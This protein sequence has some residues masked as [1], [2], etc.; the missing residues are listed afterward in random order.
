MRAA[1]TTAQ[2]GRDGHGWRPALH[3]VG[4]LERV[5]YFA[6]VEA[7]KARKRGQGRT[8][9]DIGAGTNI[10]GLPHRGRRVGVLS[11]ANVGDSSYDR[12]WNTPKAILARSV[13]QAERRWE[14][15][16]LLAAQRFFT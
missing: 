6:C 2:G 15:P 13:S 16:K 3:N 9:V 5:D 12:P 1:H 7:E 14:R 8:N 4:R 10:D 11:A